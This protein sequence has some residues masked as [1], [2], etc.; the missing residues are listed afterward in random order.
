MGKEIDAK[1]LRKLIK[2]IV[3]VVGEEEE[4][5]NKTPEG[6]KLHEEFIEG[7][8]PDASG[9]EEVGEA[10]SEPEGKKKSNAM[11]LFAANLSKKYSK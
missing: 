1:E 7:D 2:Q 8:K 10:D 5:E 3:T 6:R 11:A 4:Y 9:P